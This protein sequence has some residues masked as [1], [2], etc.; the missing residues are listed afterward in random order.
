MEIEQ[1]VEDFG[2][3]TEFFFITMELANT[4]FISTLQNYNENMDIMKKIEEHI[5]YMNKNDFICILN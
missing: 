4:G 5:K 3:I 1:K 2:T